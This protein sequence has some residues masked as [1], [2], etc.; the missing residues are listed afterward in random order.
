MNQEV[1]NHT[2][3]R[4]KAKGK[5]ATYRWVALLVLLAATIGGVLLYWR[6]AALYPST[7][8]A[9]TGANV[10]RVASQVSGPVAHVYVRDSD[11]VASRDPLFDIDPTLYD[12]ALRNAR[13][14]FD[15]AASAAGTAADALKGAAT[16]LEEKR[17]ALE[18]GPDQISRGQGS[19]TAGRSALRGAHRRLE[20]VAR[21]RAG[22]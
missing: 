2:P 17:V 1:S 22:L 15:A 4:A 5:A 14:Q 10:V 16:K 13:A 20:G 7:D 3:P 8:N 18:D 19:T 9:Y 21:R 12:A 11:K 6:Y